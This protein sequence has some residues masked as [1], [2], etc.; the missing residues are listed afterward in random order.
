MPALSQSPWPSNAQAQLQAGQIIA[1]AARFRKPIVSCSATLDGARR[2]LSPGPQ[3][4]E[5]GEATSY[6]EYCERY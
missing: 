6:P 2:R 4:R 3:H 5:R 1:R